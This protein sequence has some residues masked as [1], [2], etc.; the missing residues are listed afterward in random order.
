MDFPGVFLGNPRTDPA[1][2]HSLLEFSDSFVVSQAFLRD[3]KMMI[4]ILFA[5][6][7]QRGVGRGFEKRVSRG[8]TLKF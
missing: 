7:S 4:K 5:R 1:N 8:A 2:S 6:L 3:A